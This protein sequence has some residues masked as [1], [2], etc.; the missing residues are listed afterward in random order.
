MQ[1]TVLGVRDTVNKTGKQVPSCLRSY[2]QFT[3][4]E[5]EAQK[6]GE[7]PHTTEYRYQRLGFKPI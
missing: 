3:D 6:G 5:T 4:K 1:G 7:V 2:L